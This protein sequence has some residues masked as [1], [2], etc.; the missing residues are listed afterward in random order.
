VERARGKGKGEKE[1]GKG[2]GKERIQFRGEVCVIAFAF[3]RP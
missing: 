3:R 2:G 1:K